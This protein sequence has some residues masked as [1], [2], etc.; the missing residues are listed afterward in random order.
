MNRDESNL[1]Q[2]A[3]YVSAFNVSEVFEPFFFENCTS[4]TDFSFS[5]DIS[6]VDSAGSFC[7]LNN[8]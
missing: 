4:Q 2:M 6:H 7:F 8:S 3:N 5:F 1:I